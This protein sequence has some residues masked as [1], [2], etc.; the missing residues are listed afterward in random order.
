MDNE[1]AHRET[2]AEIAV[3]AS[4]TAAV[5]AHRQATTSHSFVDAGSTANNIV[6]NNGN[7]EPC[8]ICLDDYA[9]GDTVRLLDCKHIFHTDCID[10]YLSRTSAKCPL[11][12]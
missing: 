8:S 7:A 12:R 10:P 1:D 3:A 2:E 6:N 5:A 11:C 9:V 4:A